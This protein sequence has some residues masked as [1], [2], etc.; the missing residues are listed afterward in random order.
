[1]YTLKNGDRMRKQ[2]NVHS[3]A[4][5]YSGPYLKAPVILL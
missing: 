5:F 3:T 4:K 2:N 1:M